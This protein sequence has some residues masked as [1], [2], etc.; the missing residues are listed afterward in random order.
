LVNDRDQQSAIAPG[1]GGGSFGDQTAEDH[2]KQAQCRSRFPPNGF[3][4]KN[5]LAILDTETRR[6]VLNPDRLIASFPLAARS[7]G[8]TADLC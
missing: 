8:R 3:G 7:P 4:K 6:K 2:S 5:A 1:W